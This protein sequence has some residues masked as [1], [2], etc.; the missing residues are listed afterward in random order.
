MKNEERNEI[1]GKCKTTVFN[2]RNR[3]RIKKPLLITENY[4]ETIMYSLEKQIPQKAID[5]NNFYSCPCCKYEFPDIGGIAE[6]YGE[7]EKYDYCPKCGQ[8]IE[9]EK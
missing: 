9:Y 5:N 6:S 1:I 7:S 4:Y 8:A 3:K 2:F